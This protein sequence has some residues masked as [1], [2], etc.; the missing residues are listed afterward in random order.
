MQ[1]LDDTS[2]T[3]LLKSIG[4]NSKEMADL[5][6]IRQL[7]SVG[8]GMSLVGAAGLGAMGGGALALKGARTLLNKHKPIERYLDLGVAQIPLGKARI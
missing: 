7:A 1:V 3:H 8:S 5:D 2:L 4:N 6:A